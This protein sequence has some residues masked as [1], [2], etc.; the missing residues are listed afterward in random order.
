MAAC[1]VGSAAPPR[2]T[3]LLPARDES[4]LSPLRRCSELAG[5]PR[6][7]LSVRLRQ[8]ARWLL[9]L[10]LWA[11]LTT[12]L[13]RFGLTLET[14]QVLCV[15]PEAGGGGGML[16]VISTTEL[17]L[18]GRPRVSPVRGLREPSLQFWP[19]RLVYG[20]DPRL[21]ARRELLEEALEAAPGIEQFACVARYRSGR[22]GQF[23]GHL[24]LLRCRMQDWPMRAETAEGV[25]CWLPVAE[26]VRD[27][28]EA[29]VQATSRAVLS[30][31]L[32]GHPLPAVARPCA[33]DR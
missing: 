11:P 10:T 27:L 21:D 33:A 22:F 32:Q 30:A 18:W 15:D 5:R 12:L 14:V 24:Y 6:P 28:P 20:E 17:D 31:V 2:R 9:K 8:R 1:N 25:S 3:A 7:T 26:F 13:D 29:P 16:L 19:P 4:P 23:D